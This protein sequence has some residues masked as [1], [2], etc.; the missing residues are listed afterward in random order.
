MSRRASRL[1]FG[2]NLLRGYPGVI[3]AR[4]GPQPSN[5]TVDSKPAMLAPSVL[6]HAEPNN[7]LATSSHRDE[8]EVR[9]QPGWSAARTPDFA[10]INTTSGRSFYA[11]S[12]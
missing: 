10:P 2:T 12:A 6:L 4:E 8:A 5:K 3:V 7:L 1:R 11:A 9:R